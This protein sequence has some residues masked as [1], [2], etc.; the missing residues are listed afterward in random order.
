MKLGHLA[1]ETHSTLE[2]GSPD[3]E[4]SST[5]G[6]NMAGPEDVSFLA[7]PKYTPQ[8]ATKRAGSVY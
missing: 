7:N 6:L 4:I 1:E 2:R 3:L 5:A 8:I